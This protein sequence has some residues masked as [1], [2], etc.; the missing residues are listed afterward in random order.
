[1]PAARSP[2][3]RGSPGCRPG[4]SCG[5]SSPRPPGLVVSNPLCPRRLPVRPGVLL[6]AE[7]QNVGGAE[8]ASARYE[9]EG[10]WDSPGLPIRLRLGRGRGAPSRQTPEN[11]NSSCRKRPWVQ[12][13]PAGKLSIKIRLPWTSAF[14]AVSAVFCASSGWICGAYW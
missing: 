10:A 6:K 1:M 5:A 12:T 14:Q 13:E 3:R 7:D 8:S 4:C 9:G 2:R 11:L